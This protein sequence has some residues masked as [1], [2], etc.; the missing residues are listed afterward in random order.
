MRMYDL[1]S[2]VS[3]DSDR[4]AIINHDQLSTW[5]QIAAQIEAAREW[6]RPLERSRVGFCLIPTGGGF[7][8][9]AALDRLH[10]DVFLLDHQI[11]ESPR[12]DLANTFGFSAIVRP[13]ETHAP[14]RGEI[15]LVDKDAARPDSAGVTLLTSGT[16]G[17]P[18]AV[19]HTWK[20][21]SRPV[22]TTKTG[23]RQRWLLAFR[24]HL[25]AGLQVI[26]QC[27]M[28]RGT[29]VV[30]RHDATP[31]EVVA[32]IADNRVDHVSATPSY[33]R[34]LCLF[35]NRELRGAT[36][37][38]QITLGGEMV[39]QLILDL[40]RDSFPTARIAHIYATTELGRCFSV[41]DGQAGFPLTYLGETT[42]DGIEL[43]IRDGLLWVRSPNAMLGYEPAAADAKTTHADTDGWFCTG[44]MVEARHDRVFFVGRLGE[45]INVGGGKVQP[46]VVEDAIRQVPGVADVCVFG[47][48]SSITGQLVACQVVVTE[49][50]DPQQVRKAVVEQ[51]AARLDQVK[52]PRLIEI[53]DRIELTNAG[54]VARISRMILKEQ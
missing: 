3:D 27:L 35:A 30:P 13:S 46:T 43:K 15:Q 11:G 18:K 32:M 16:E 8:A 37:I 17:R 1:F 45:T 2:N 9:L 34:R 31:D 39:D 21:L 53:T 38:H 5:S 50:H 33:W 20:S 4:P 44:D 48:P 23:A 47:Q 7:A 22:R 14:Q 26:L 28:N 49:G 51:C 40:L 54:K 29:L 10:C 52:R 41:T 12:C 6:L 36:E 42:A 24:P 25:Y 19:R